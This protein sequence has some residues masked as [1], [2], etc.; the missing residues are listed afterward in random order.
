MML[1]DY[2]FLTDFPLLTVKCE[3]WIDEGFKYDQNKSRD[4]AANW[5][6]I[7]QYETRTRRNLTHGVEDVVHIIYRGS[8]Y[9]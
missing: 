3:G 2:L 5:P 9:K 6:L 4:L 7:Y 8:K 1:F